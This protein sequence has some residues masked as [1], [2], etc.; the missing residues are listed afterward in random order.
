V[1]G[2]GPRAEGREYEHRNQKAVQLDPGEL[3]L[4]TWCQ[5]KGVSVRVS[6][7]KNFKLQNTNTKWFDKP[8]DR[9]TVLSKIEG[10]TTLSIVEG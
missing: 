4:I 9:L 7:I 2:G 8:F 3:I 5:K 1:E 10:F 6:E